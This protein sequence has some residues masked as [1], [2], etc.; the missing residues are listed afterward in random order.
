MAGSQNIRK[1]AR[2]LD[3]GGVIAYPTEG[4]FGLGCLPDDREAVG[5]I[6]DIKSRNPEMGLILI[7]SAVH[8]LDGWT[9]LPD[10][11]LSLALDNGDPVTWILPAAADVPDW[12]RGSHSSIAVRLTTHPVARAL[13]DAVDFPLVSTS[14]NVSGHLPARNAWVLRRQF[15]SLVDYI[16]PGLCGP[17]TGPSEIRDL[18]TGEIVR[19]A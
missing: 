14:A 1:A 12:I 18:L 9:D 13:C 17:A 16:V 11:D 6:L 5:R 19:P 15:G 7:I 8:Q 2:V 3:A 10:R 4:I